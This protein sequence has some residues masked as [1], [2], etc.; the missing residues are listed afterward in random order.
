MRVERCY[1]PV[2][3]I[4]FVGFAWVIRVFRVN[5]IDSIDSVNSINPDKLPPVRIWRKPDEKTFIFKFWGH[6]SIYVG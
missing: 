2:L 6:I 5:T 1:T 4:V 3:L